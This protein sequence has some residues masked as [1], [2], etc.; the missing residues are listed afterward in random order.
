MKKQLL[1]MYSVKQ[2]M[3]NP[4][5]K[6][7]GVTDTYICKCTVEGLEYILNQSLSLRQRWRLTRVAKGNFYF[8]YS[9]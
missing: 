9:I 7:Y 1:N 6:I 8:P 3:K 5:H 4:P 2:F